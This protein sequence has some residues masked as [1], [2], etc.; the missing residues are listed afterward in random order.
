[1][2]TSAIGDRGPN[3]PAVAFI[4]GSVRIEGEI[5]S[6]E[7]LCVEGEVRGTIDASQHRLTVGT[8]GKVHAGIKAREAVISGTVEGNIEAVERIDIRSH[9]TVLGDLSTPCITVEDG[10]LLRCGVNIRGS[11]P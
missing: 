3:A 11:E 2:S 8:T 6:N 10:A 9:A 1:M 7:D 4:G 5:R